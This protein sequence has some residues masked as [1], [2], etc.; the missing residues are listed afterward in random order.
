M[1]QMLLPTT[2]IA[3]L[4]PSEVADRCHIS[5]PLFVSIKLSTKPDSI[6]TRKSAIKMFS[7]QEQWVL[8]SP[9]AQGLRH[10]LNCHCRNKG[11]AERVLHR[12]GGS[13][14]TLRREV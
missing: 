4:P 7:Q 8:G 6:S 14:H 9:S 12:G 3:S 13:Q 2:R 1:L 10:T 5:D 11:K